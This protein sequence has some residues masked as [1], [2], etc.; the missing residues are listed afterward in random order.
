MIYTYILSFIGPYYIVNSLHLL[1]SAINNCFNL[2]S[3]WEV[4]H[5]QREFKLFYYNMIPVT[6]CS[7][8][9]CCCGIFLYAYIIFIGS[10]KTQKKAC[11]KLS[12][13]TL[14]TNLNILIFK[15]DIFYSTWWSILRPKTFLGD[16]CLE[17]QKQG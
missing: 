12:R 5:R 13:L 3:V 9:L 17:L 4:C 14:T 10:T 8:W 11:L 7:T 2:W 6:Y 16:N 1:D 15:V